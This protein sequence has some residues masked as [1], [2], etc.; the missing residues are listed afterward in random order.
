MRFAGEYPNRNVDLFAIEPDPSTFPDYTSIPEYMLVLATETSGGDGYWWFLDTQRGTMTL[1]DGGRMDS[2]V[3][4]K[5]TVDNDPIQEGVNDSETWREHP[6]CRVAEFFEMLKEHY[7]E[8]KLIPQSN[9]VVAPGSPGDMDD[10]QIKIYKDCGW[11]DLTTYRKD[12]CIAR[13][14]KMMD[15]YRRTKEIP[16]V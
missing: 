2:P 4:E 7:T 3:K 14:E 1:Y 16:R 6:T 10:A 8:L 11:P 15:E 5:G 9:D 12:E 13:I